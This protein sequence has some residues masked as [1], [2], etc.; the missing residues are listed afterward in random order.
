MFIFYNIFQAVLGVPWCLRR[1]SIV[2]HLCNAKASRQNHPR[3]WVFISGGCSGRG[4][5][6]IGVVSY[7][8]LVHNITQITTACFHCTPL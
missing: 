2:Q 6:W 8:K 1:L 7:N 5:Q 3:L 4:V